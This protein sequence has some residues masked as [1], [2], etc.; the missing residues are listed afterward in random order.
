MNN[1][2]AEGIKLNGLKAGRTL[3]IRTQVKCQRWLNEERKCKDVCTNISQAKETDCIFKRK[4]NKG[5]LI[6]LFFFAIF[7]KQIMKRLSTAVMFVF[8]RDELLKAE[9]ERYA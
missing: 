1:T 4:E 2:S 3:H 9:G 8:D 7:T 6:L 5:K